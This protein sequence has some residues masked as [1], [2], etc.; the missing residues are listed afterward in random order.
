MNIFNWA[1]DNNIVWIENIDWWIMK[2]SLR[3]YRLLHPSNGLNKNRAEKICR[4]MFNTICINS[5]EQL[6]RLIGF[7]DDEEDFYYI[8]KDQHGKIVWESMVGYLIPLKGKISNEDYYRI[9]KGFSGWVDGIGQCPPEKEFLSEY[10]P[11]KFS[12]Q[13][14][15]EEIE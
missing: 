1:Q 5:M 11:S 14:F 2:K 10:E 4:L 9:E 13:N 3:L 12:F 6:V 8:T 7:G 15:T